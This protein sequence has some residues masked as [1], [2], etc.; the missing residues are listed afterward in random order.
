M[1]MTTLDPRTAL[2]V[3]DLQRGIV[4][5]ELAPHP[6][7]DVVGHAA[8][9]VERFRAHDLPVVFVTVAGA[10]PGRTDLSDGS[11]RE[12]PAGWDELIDEFA[13]RADDLAVVKHSVSAFSGTGLAEGLRERGVTQVVVVGIA[14]G[15]G[16][17][18]T[19]R[20]AHEAGFHVTLPVDAMTDSDETR[21]RYSLTSI[22]P[23]IAETGSTAE[24][25]ELLDATRR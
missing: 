11:A 17:E 7:M 9:L 4:G 23:R 6:A 25:L 22:F 1:A 10:P 18:S 2:I 19:A 3:V 16:V 8:D 12:L 21:H 14:T 24:L 20:D 5:R 13:P 15:A